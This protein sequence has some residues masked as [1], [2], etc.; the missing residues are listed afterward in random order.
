[1]IFFAFHHK[2]PIQVPVELMF[3]APHLAQLELYY[4]WKTKH[5]KTKKHPRK[6]SHDS[7]MAAQ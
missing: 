6:H 4:A 7:K 3:E 5:D 2:Q 1:M